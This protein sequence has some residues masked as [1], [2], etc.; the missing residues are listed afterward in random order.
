MRRLASVLVAT[1][2]AG[3]VWAGMLRGSEYL[4]PRIKPLE[5]VQKFFQS[6]YGSPAVKPPVETRA[7]APAAA[8]PPAERTT[9]P[10]LALPPHLVAVVGVPFSIYYDNIVLATRPDDYSVSIRADGLP[11]KS[12]RRR[13]SLM[14]TRDQVGAHQ[15]TV[16]VS[17]LDGTVVASGKTV[18]QVVTADSPSPPLSVLLVGDSI[19]QQNLYPNQLWTRLDA[20][21]KGRVRFVGTNQPGLIHRTVR[22]ALPKVFHEGYGGW[23]YAMFATHYAPDQSAVYKIPRS[24]F[25]FFEEGAP[26]L[27]VARYLTEQNAKNG[28]DVVILEAG[29]NDTFLLNPD[30]PA[31]TDQGIDSVIANVDKLVAAFRQASPQT[32]VGIV[33][34]PPFTRSAATFE[35]VYGAAGANLGDPWRHRRI[36]HR[37]VEKMIAHWGQTPDQ[38]VFLVP[39]YLALDTVDGY[40]NWDAGHPNEY[41]SAQVADSVY[42]AIIDAL[43]K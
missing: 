22:P 21:T 20:L 38:K 1:V 34:P 25:V 23:T 13:W 30:D 3:A 16:E 32:K 42:A 36:Q 10:R 18:L 9:G 29:L 24:P 40:W 15:V 17:K 39:T 6:V 41:G 37:V 19:T 14:A 43:K 8:A 35:H 2:V 12:E 27:N 7:S 33:L 31:A 5:R 28:L 26:R 4:V 11:D